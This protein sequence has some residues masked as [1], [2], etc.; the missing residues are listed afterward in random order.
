VGREIV[1]DIRLAMTIECLEEDGDVNANANADAEQAG[2]EQAGDEHSVASPTDEEMSGCVE[3][4]SG[5]SNHV[6]SHTSAAT[7][8]QFQYSYAINP[9]TVLV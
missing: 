9:I 2:D 7:S 1:E 4:A 5:C 6:C 3:N 8:I